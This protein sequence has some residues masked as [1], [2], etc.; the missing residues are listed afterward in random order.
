MKTEWHWRRSKDAEKFSFAITEI[1]YILKYIQIEKS[2]LNC[3]IS[4]YY[5]TTIYTYYCLLYFDSNLT[6]VAT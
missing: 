2:Y 5:C 3:N 1:N 4:Q 6:L